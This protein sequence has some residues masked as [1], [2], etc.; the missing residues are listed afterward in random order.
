M[1]NYLKWRQR[2]DLINET[3]VGFN[4]CSGL[5]GP[6]ASH[7]K[8]T[9]PVFANFTR[10]F[11]PYYCMNSG[12]KYIQRALTMNTNDSKT[13]M[14]SKSHSQK[15]IWCNHCRLNILSS[16]CFVDEAT[17][18]IIHTH[19]HRHQMLKINC[20]LFLTLPN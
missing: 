14:T 2:V 1:V 16:K 3:L 19:H 7:L 13:R 17:I 4:A 6:S 8:T 9:S 11:N 15:Q 12:M 20:I 10:W 18:A 5:N